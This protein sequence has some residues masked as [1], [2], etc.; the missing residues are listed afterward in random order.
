MFTRV[1]CYEDLKFQMR[2]KNTYTLENIFLKI[3]FKLWV[4]ENIKLSESWLR[5]VSKA[6]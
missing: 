1:I 4:Y 2:L 3:V 5:N 6:F